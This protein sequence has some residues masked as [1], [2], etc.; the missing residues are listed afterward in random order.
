M[1]DNEVRKS[2]YEETRRRLSRYKNSFELDDREIIEYLVEE[3]EQYREKIKQLEYDSK[4]IKAIYHAEIYECTDG[5]TEVIYECD[6]DK[7]KECDKKNCIPEYCTHTTNKKYARNYY[8][9]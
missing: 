2:K 1:P 9:Q 5:T 3:I 4:K 8:K 7:C 6:K